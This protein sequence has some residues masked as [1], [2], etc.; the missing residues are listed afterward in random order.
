MFSFQRASQLVPLHRTAELHKSPSAKV[1]KRLNHAATASAGGDLVGVGIYDDFGNA[2]GPVLTNVGGWSGYKTFENDGGLISQRSGVDGGIL[3]LANDNTDDDSVS[4]QTGYATGSMGSISRTAGARKMALFGARFALGQV[5]NTK[6]DW[7]I[8]LCSPGAAKND[9]FFADNGTM[10]GGDATCTNS[11]IGFMVRQAAGATL[12]FVYA[13]AGAAIT[14]PIAALATLTADT[15][16]KCEFVYN[17]EAEASRKIA[18]FLNGA[19]QSTYITDTNMAATTF[20]NGDAL[21]MFAELKNA[22]GSTS[23]ADLDWWYG[24]FAN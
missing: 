13:N 21:S 12:N 2:G 15:M 10:I 6:T 17:P 16:V 8:G 18:C 5:A 7:F 11:F 14:T 4:I 23:Y 20:P 19:E 9:G 24:F 3:R 1:L 22:A